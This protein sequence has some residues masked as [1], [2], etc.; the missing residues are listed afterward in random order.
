[1]MVVRNGLSLVGHH[2]VKEEEV[3]CANELNK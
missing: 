3:P 1:M 2:I